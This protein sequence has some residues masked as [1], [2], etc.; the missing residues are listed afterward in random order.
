MLLRHVVCLHCMP[1]HHSP[2]SHWSRPAV[3]VASMVVRVKGER[4]WLELNLLLSFVQNALPSLFFLTFIQYRPLS[5]AK[6]LLPAL[7]KYG[8]LLSEIKKEGKN[9]SE[10]E[11]RGDGIQV[12]C[13]VTTGNKGRRRGVLIS[14]QF[15]RECVCVCGGVCLFTFF[16]SVQ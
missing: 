16:L 10:G 15:T 11:V 6:L 3:H 12:F 5:T 13:H 8:F 7:T 1:T 9:D 2:C 14:L 4:E